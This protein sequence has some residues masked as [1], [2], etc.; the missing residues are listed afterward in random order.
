MKKFNKQLHMSSCN[1]RHFHAKIKHIKLTRN[2]RTTKTTAAGDELSLEIAADEVSDFCEMIVK[3]V[4]MVGSPKKVLRTGYW[5]DE[6]MS[7][8]ICDSSYD[9]IRGKRS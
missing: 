5:Q 8:N 9:S 6:L 7:W 1:H 3:A 2:K 4:E